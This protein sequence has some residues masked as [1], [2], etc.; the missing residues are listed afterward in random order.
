MKQIIAMGGGGFSMEPENLSLDRYIMNQSA[1]KTPRICF[2]PTASGDSQNYVQRFYH[3]FQ[4]LDC[5]ASHLSLFKPPSTDL[6]SFVMEKDVIYVGGGNTRNMLVLWKEWGLDLILREAWKNGVV[7]AGLSAGAICW[8]A[9]GV[10]DSAGPLT[11]MKSLGFLQRSF[12]PHY[13]GEKDRR[14]IY[15]QLICNEF[16]CEGYAA[17]DG[18][19]L[20]FINNRLFQTVSSRPGAKAYRVTRG[21]HEIFETPLPVKYLG[22]IS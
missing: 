1:R 22:R 13:D 17:D 5:V 11:S 3:T 20:H 18:A 14:P 2:L 12:C 9:E 10:T 4:T 21:E 19:A 8:F 7:L 16:L 15:H 6:T